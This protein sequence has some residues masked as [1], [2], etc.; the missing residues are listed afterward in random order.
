MSA[1]SPVAASTWRLL[2]LSLLLFSIVS[3][4]LA[5]QVAIVRGQSAS[6]GVAEI[7]TRL[8][9]E[10]ELSGWLVQDFEGEPAQALGRWRDEDA[11]LA[12]VDLLVTID[13]R[14]GVPCVDVW[15]ADPATGRLRARRLVGGDSDRSSPAALALRAAEHLRATAAELELARERSAK[16]TTPQM[17]TKLAEPPPSAAPPPPPPQVTERRTT[18]DPLRWELGL[19]GGRQPSALAYAFGAHLGA[20]QPIS[21]QFAATAA[22]DLPWFGN[23]VSASHGKARFVPTRFG[24]GL[25]GVL[26]RFSP[27]TLSLQ[28]SLGANYVRVTGTSAPD[29]HKTNDSGWYADALVGLQLRR[30]LGRSFG[31]GLVANVAEPWPAPVVVFNRTSQGTVGVPAAWLTAFIDGAP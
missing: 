19:V 14:A 4:A 29:G 15:I 2:R 1:A 12:G 8:H 31:Y 28:G 17:P 16:P 10:L 25:S 3:P 27:W 23:Q 22:I 5:E 9:G 13:E 11:A 24:F 7:A 21:R 26:A 18:N 6:P 30:S 20:F